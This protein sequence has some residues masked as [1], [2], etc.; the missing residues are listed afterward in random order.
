MEQKQTYIAVLIIALQKK[1]VL[2]DKL[3]EITNKQKNLI[4]ARE[5]ESEVFEQ[6]LKDKEHFIDCL[7]NA[8]DGF[9][10]IYEKVK[11]EISV[12]RNQHKEEILQLQSLITL[13]T[14][15]SVVLQA[16]EQRNYGAM[17]NFFAQKKKEIREFHL[18]DRSTA[19]YYRNMADQHQG[20]SYFMDKKK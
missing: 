9:E 3:L 7:N 2:L 14:E 12:N 11:Q 8:D 13:I 6:L 17:Q 15:K 1:S 16:E 20:Q 4:G 18:N 19:S 5:A 10:L